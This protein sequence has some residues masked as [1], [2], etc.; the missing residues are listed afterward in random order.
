MRFV[1]FTKLFGTRPVLEMAETIRELQFDGVDLLI[2]T[3][4]SVPPDQPELVGKAIKLF[5]A[6]GLEVP[7]ATTDL[8]A[9]GDYPAEAVLSQC[10][11]E[12]V[13]LIRL[14][15]WK[16]DQRV[17]YRGQ[18]DQARRD[19]DAIE[20]LAH[21]FG[22]TFLIQVHGET[23]HNSAA[24]TLPLL[25]GRD[26]A[27]VAAYMDPGNQAVQDGREDWR[28]TLDILRPWLRCVGVKNGGWSPTEVAPSGQLQW[29]SRWMPISDGMVPWDL[30]IAGLRASDFD[31]ELS[32]HSHYEVPYEQALDVTR[33]DLRYVRRLLSDG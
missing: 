31:G 32:F 12:G 10:R 11:D 29:R 3:G 2:R 25:S 7:M 30:V 9:P 17:G 14:G 22:V 23:I 15:F 5:R 6:V 24:L 16:Y 33:S 18:F 1:M 13:D 8:T 28:M 26:P 27:V 4:F 20:A 21:G 19:L